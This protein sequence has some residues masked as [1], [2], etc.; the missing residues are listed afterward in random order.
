MADYVLN[1]QPNSMQG[2]YVNLTLLFVLGLVQWFWIVPRIWKNEPDIQLLKF[3]V[4]GS[5]VLLPESKASDDF[6][7]YA[8]RDITPLERILNDND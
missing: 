4:G 3:P 5:R 6:E 1:V 7:F 8:S 2:M